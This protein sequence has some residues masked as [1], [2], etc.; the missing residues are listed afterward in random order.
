MSVFK[1]LPLIIVAASIAA[2]DRL[3]G[4][5]STIDAA[6][7]PSIQAALDAVP[8]TGGEVRLPAGEF[9]IN[10]PLVIRTSDTSLTGTG[11][12]THIHN[13]N[14]QGQ[15]A[16]II[17]HPSGEDKRSAELWRIRLADLRISGNEK[18]GHGIEARRINEIF[19][20]GVTLSFHG[21]DGIR[22]D[23]CYEDPR[24][25]DCL[26]TYN[27]QMG[28]NLIGCHD[29]IVSANQFEENRDALLCAD[30]FNLTFNG[31]NIDDHLRHG[32]RIENTY[33]SVVSGNMIEECQGWAIILDR[34]CYG[35]TLSAN[36]IAHDF[37]GGIDLVDAHGC[38]LSA[39]TFTIVKKSA[40]AIRPGSGRI[41]I[42]GNNFSDSYIGGQDKRVETDTP[43]EKDQNEATGILLD[44]TSDLAIT[45]NV[46]SGLSTPAIRA[47]GQPSKRILFANNLISDTQAE[48]PTFEASVVRD[49]LT[50]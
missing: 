35:I 4:S 41:V 42:T 36:V 50:N 12:A 34:D 22:L 47:L 33:G 37:A 25:A 9:K 39:N 2:A 16:L 19:I 21:G 1:I 48:L 5:R 40:I 17:Q 29:I 10:Q 26:L 13:A 32:V 43:T 27:K 49:N 15:P 7:Y 45:G 3:P 46:F 44:S 14:T 23:K 6:Q 11:T 31:N 24:I 8:E 38:T 20:D 28:V 18:S 30:S